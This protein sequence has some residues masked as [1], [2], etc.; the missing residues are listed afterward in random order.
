MEKTG[1]TFRLKCTPRSTS[2]GRG[3]SKAIRGFPGR[4]PH[5]TNFRPGVAVDPRR[6]EGSPGGVHI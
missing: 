3:R 6:S 1:P 4:S 5:L 2:R